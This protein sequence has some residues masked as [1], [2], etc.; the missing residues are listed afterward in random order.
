MSRGSTGERLFSNI[1]TST[2]YWFIHS[3]IIP[4]LFVVGW[5]FAGTGLAYDVFGTPGSTEQSM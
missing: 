3:I 2:R 1:V 4:S 5:L